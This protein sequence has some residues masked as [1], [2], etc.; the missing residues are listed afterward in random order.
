MTGRGVVCGDEGGGCGH[1]GTACGTLLY[2]EEEGDRFGDQRKDELVRV[3]DDEVQTTV[4]PK[5]NDI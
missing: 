3:N 2:G 5:Y 1:S 4:G